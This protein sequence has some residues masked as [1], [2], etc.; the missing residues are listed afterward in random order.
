[1][2]LEDVRCQLFPV[3][4][5]KKSVNIKNNEEDLSPAKLPAKTV[6]FEKRRLKPTTPSKLQQRQPPPPIYTTNDIGIFGTTK[7]KT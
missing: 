3:P 6:L 1:M 4:R 7:S 5:R 2:E